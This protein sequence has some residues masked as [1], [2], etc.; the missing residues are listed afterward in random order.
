M[1]K[2]ISRIFHFSFF[3]LHISLAVSAQD[4]EQHRPQFHFTPKSGWMNDPNGLVFYAGEY[5]LFY[6]HYPDGTTWGPMHWGHAVSKD[7]VQWEHLPIALYPDSLGY[8]FSGSAVVDEYNTAG[9]QKGKEKAL[10]AIYTY[11]NMEYEKAG[12]KDR[13]SQGIA[14]SLDKGRTWTKYAGNPVVKNKGDEDFRDPKVFWHEPTKN[15]CMTLAV[16]DHAEIFT[17]PNLKDWK[18]ASSFG[19]NAGAHGGVWECPDL[20]RY[21][22]SD[23]KEK[24]VLM[25]NLNPGAPNGG[26]GVQY[27]VGDFDGK[28]FTNDNSPEKTMWFDLGTDN[29]AGVT[30]SGLPKNRNVV[31][32]W[33]S[34]WGDYAQTVPTKTWRSAT[35]IARDIKLLKTEAGYRLYQLPVKELNVILDAAAT[36]TESKTMNVDGK[37]LHK[38]ILQHSLD[39][40]FDLKKATSTEI[41]F[42]LSN[43]LNEKLVVGFDLKNNKC[44]VDRTNAGKKDFSKVFAAVHTADYQFGDKL[45]VKVLIDRASIEFFV[46]NGKLAMTEIFFPNKDFDKISLFEKGKGSTLTQSKL[47]PIKSILR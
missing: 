16:H 5:H 1:R 14:Y 24:W 31:I 3:I 43:D 12:R 42:E 26:S 39:L 33:M 27:F 34:N 23:G 13:E 11:H 21:I 10:V 19:K 17:S 41:G 29:Y 20:S 38:G 44:Y 25:Q 46:D 35:T 6:Q 15:W 40:S 47:I 32:G 37:V 22:A 8:I 18:Y 9:F 36:K 30:W 2:N 28:V 7:L 45:T 4:I